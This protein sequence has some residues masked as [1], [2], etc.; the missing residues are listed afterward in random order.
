MPRPRGTSVRI[1]GKVDRRFAA[2]RLVLLLDGVRF[3]AGTTVGVDGSISGSG[4]V[5]GPANR[6]SSTVT[7]ATVD[8]R[9]VA[10]SSFDFTSVTGSPRPPWPTWL[11]FAIAILVLGAAAGLRER[12]RQQ[13]RWVQQHVRT[14]A[15]SSPGQAHAEPDTDAPTFS[16]RLQPHTDTGTTEITKE[17]S[18]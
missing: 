7:L 14:E 5:S 11:L 9:A 8:G 3:G 6:R 15:H 2:C 12:E 4:T 1:G 17:G 10:A 13:R 16:V 18:R